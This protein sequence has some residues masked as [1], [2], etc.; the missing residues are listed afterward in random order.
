MKRYILMKIGYWLWILA[1]A[2]KFNYG[3]YDPIIIGWTL[4]RKGKCVLK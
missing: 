3:K 2:Y 1:E 4:G